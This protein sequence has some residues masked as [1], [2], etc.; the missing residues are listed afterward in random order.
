[1]RDLGVAVHEAGHAVALVAIGEVPTVATVLPNGQSS[2][3]GYRGWV[4]HSRLARSADDLM[5]NVA[6][7]MAKLLHCPAADPGWEGDV[8]HAIKNIEVIDGD[9]GTTT[10]V[11]CDVQ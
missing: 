7:P 11:A 4:S 9:G 8:R 6:G 10:P 3:K 2:P 1:M 5:V